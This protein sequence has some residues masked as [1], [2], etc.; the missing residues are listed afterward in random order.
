M[1]MGGRPGRL[2]TIGVIRGGGEA[3]YCSRHVLGGVDGVLSAASSEEYESEE[4]DLTFSS[5]SIG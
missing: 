3:W 1:L 4:G 2:T 5:M